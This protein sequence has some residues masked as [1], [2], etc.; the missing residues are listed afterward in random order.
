MH[1]TKEG[2]RLVKLASG[3][4]SVHSLAH[5][6]T[7][8]PVIGPVAEAEALYVK[9]LH[10]PE[11]MATHTGEFV[12][13]DVG[14]GAAAN[15][16]TVLKAT[17]A[18]TCPLRIISFDH[19]IAPLQ[20]ALDHATDLGYF[21]GYESAVDDFL[22]HQRATFTDGSRTVNWELHLGD[23]PT[24]VTQTLANTAGKPPAPHAIL[25]DAFSPAKNPAMWTQ[26]LFANLFRL[27]DPQRPCALP[28][29]SRSTMLRVSLLLADFYVGAGHATGEKEETTIAANSLDLISEPLDKTWLK[30]A[31]NSTS[32]EP[33]WE[34]SYR[35]APLAPATWEKL[36]QHPQFK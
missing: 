18:A 20:F 36:Q 15:V 29:Y 7:F 2:Y 21:T 33:M 5:R 8:H 16:L 12:I 11:R 3:V 32:A 26:P 23:F 22:K 34:P 19:T 14:L 17:R 35:Q 4:H 1:S 28:T 13:W 25:F 9:Q 27:L 24:F 6:E 10:L 30:R 31:Q